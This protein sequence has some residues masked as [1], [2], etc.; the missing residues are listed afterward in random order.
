MKICP[1]CK[2]ECADDTVFCQTCGT[3]LSSVQP[4]GNEAPTFCPKCGNKLEAGTVFCPKCGN[5]LDGAAP[6]K[7]AQGSG[8]VNDLV[9]TLKTFFTK[10]PDAAV[11]RAAKSTGLAWT[12]FGGLSIL[13]LMLA[14]P[15]N[16]TQCIISVIRKASAGLV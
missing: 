13:A 10:S 5:R 6:V 11:G 2:A 16:I 14:L 15:T 7:Q 1:N 12:V 3:N 4:Q 9:G 8:L